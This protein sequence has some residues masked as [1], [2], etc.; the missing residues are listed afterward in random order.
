MVDCSVHLFHLPAFKHGVAPIAGLQRKWDDNDQ[1]RGDATETTRNKRLQLEETKRHF[2][3]CFQLLL[4]GRHSS[5][6]CVF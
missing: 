3:Q 1:I 4:D 6:S 5:E 2:I